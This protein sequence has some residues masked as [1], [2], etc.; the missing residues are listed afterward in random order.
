MKTNQTALGNH[1]LLCHVAAADLD[2]EVCL[3]SLIQTKV[4]HW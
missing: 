3:P 2:R 1:Q 4:L